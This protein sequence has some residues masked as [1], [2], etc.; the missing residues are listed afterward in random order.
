[1][2]QK[3]LKAIT[4]FIPILFLFFLL[5][6]KDYAFDEDLGR[7]IKS[8]ELILRCHCLPITN[9]FSYTFPSFPWFTNSWF[10]TVVLYEAF[11][12]F[13]KQALLYLKFAL[14][15]FTFLPI[16][17][18]S[19]KRISRYWTIIL[20]IPLFIIAYFRFDEL[21]PEM[22][23]FLL[24]SIFVLLIE[25]YKNT[26]QQRFLL[27]LIPLEILWVNL[28]IFFIFGIIIYSCFL[29]ERITHFHFR[30][31]KNQILLL[32][33]LILSTL[34]NPTG[35][36]IAISPF[37]IFLN[38][39]QTIVENESIF[40]FFQSNVAS[41]LNEISSLTFEINFIL[42]VTFIS[43]VI[44]SRKKVS[45]YYASVAL[46][47]IIC[48][49][50]MIRLFPLFSI[51]TFIPFIIYAKK[52]ERII[53][54]KMEESMISICKGFLFVL[55]LSLAAFYIT[56]TIHYQLPGLAIS[57]DYLPA[58]NFIQKNAISGPMFNSENMGS[59]IIFRLF[60]HDRVFT[61]A[62]PEAYPAKF[63]DEYSY[64]YIKPQIFDAWD[65][66]YKFNYV[67]FRSEIGLTSDPFVT[68]L[69]TK[70][71]WRR[72]YSDKFNTVIFLRNNDKNNK[73]EV[74]N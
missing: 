46:I 40:T 5:W 28:H 10:S 23:S 37:T 12:H 69:S 74:Q 39:G 9:I 7:H 71:D 61:D 43:M 54:E 19:Y 15:L 67:I 38:Y 45:I 6:Q 35:Y 64:L 60:P 59:Y 56:T 13:G 57:E 25:K 32:I 26:N 44:F 63:A 50:K 29:L 33:I 41:I 72:V 34:V 1:M 22:F 73:V 52:S 31:N 51:L 8:G 18:Y 3:L 58:L 16:Y 20:S 49:V 24:L 4:F 65:K 62:R 42:F 2:L 11:S 68:Y 48:A 47:G 14:L 70:K 66:Q 30:E 53:R 21:R 17:I 27:L 55:I 36:Q